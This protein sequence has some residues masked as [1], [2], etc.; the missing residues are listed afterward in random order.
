[1]SNSRNMICIMCPNGCEISAKWGEKE[2]QID[3]YL[4]EKGKKFA[5][6]EIKNPQRI[7]TTTMKVENGKRPLVSVRSDRP[8]CKDELCKLV[9]ELNSITVDSPIACGT[10]IKREVGRNRVNIIA[11]SG[12]DRID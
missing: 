2:I 10:V 4:C 11:T 3:G 8:V 12:V 1:M 7:L 9:T 6:N 5:E